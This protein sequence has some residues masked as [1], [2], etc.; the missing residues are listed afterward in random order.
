MWK[1]SEEQ[2]TKQKKALANCKGI[3]FPAMCKANCAEG[4]PKVTLISGQEES[5]EHGN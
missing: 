3:A 4:I 5:R 1:V 2:I